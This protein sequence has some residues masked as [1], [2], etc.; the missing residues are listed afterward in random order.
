MLGF[1]DVIAV[2]Q[3]LT[4]SITRFYCHG[5]VTDWPT[6]SNHAQA[7]VYFALSALSPIPFKKPYSNLE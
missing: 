5:H 6:C 1:K 3:D 2:N 4:F 7:S